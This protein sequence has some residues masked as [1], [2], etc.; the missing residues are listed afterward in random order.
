MLFIVKLTD[1]PGA[2]AIRQRLSDEIAS[3]LKEPEVVARLDGYGVEVI[4]GG[5][6]RLDAHVRKEFERWRAVIAA[7]GLLPK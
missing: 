2:L 1:K 5:P 3:I 7:G 6:D 4:A